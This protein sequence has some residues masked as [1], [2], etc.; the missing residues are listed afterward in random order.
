[1]GR[2]NYGYAGEWTDSSGLQYLRARF[3]S[4]AQS[5]FTAKDP[6]PG[7]LTQPASLTPYTYALNNPILLSEQCAQACLTAAPPHATIKE[8][9]H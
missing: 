1:M 7:L 4:P 8:T 5:R 6:F 3:Y 9:I 2:S